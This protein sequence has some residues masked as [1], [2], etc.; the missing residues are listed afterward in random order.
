[1]SINETKLSITIAA[2]R[3][4]AIFVKRIIFKVLFYPPFIPLS[5]L[6]IVNIQFLFKC[7]FGAGSNYKE[8]PKK[9]II[10]TQ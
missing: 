4:L 2:G 8:V 3:N 7:I 5:K 10:S 6:F 9:N 1:M